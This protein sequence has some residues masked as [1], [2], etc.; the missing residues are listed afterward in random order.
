MRKNM[1]LAAMIIGLG[2]LAFSQTSYVIPQGP[3]NWFRAGDY[4]T[5]GNTTFTNSPYISFNAKL[6]TSDIST[7]YNGFLPHYSG[8]GS[9]GLIIRGDAG[10]SGLH[11]LQT[12]YTSSSEV[13]MASFTESVTLTPGGLLGV[14]ASNPNSKLHIG[15]F[16][17]ANGI[18]LGDRGDVANEY[19]AT[20]YTKNSNNGELYFN[21][22]K[23]GIGYGNI[24]MVPDGGTVCIGPNVGYS[25]SYKLIV[26][27]KIGAREIKVTL[28]NPWPDYVFGSN[29]KLKSLYTVEQ[30]IKQN[31]HL[32]N[33]PSAAEVKKN[34]GINL[35]EMNAK[36]LQ[37]V[38]EL[39]LYLISLKKEVDQ[40]H[41]ENAEI[42]K[43]HASPKSK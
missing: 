8:S 13:N 2:N 33:M 37:K 29:Y 21:V 19:S 3:S 26:D 12:Q 30:F 41:Q 42:K 31:R 34:D 6:N 23:S 27:G 15:G 20:I 25:G 11:F 39:T 7:G 18:R 16:D 43:Q 38:E 40:L 4:L 36:L 32:P 1:L 10:G 17:M 28:S 14:G 9:G 35:G 24:F 5:A 22:G